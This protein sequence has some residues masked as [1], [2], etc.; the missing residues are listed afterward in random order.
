MM[1][2]GLP[3]VIQA[4]AP[5]RSQVAQPEPGILV[6]GVQ[7][8]GLPEEAPRLTPPARTRRLLAQAQQLFELLLLSALR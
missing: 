2:L 3:Q 4:L 5:I 1:S 8:K 6:G 7:Q